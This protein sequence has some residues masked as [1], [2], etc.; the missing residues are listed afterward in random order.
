MPSRRKFSAYHLTGF[1]KVCQC[2]ALQF[3]GTYSC[4]VLHRTIAAILWWHSLYHVYIFKNE[5]Y[6]DWRL[7]AIISQSVGWS[8]REFDVLSSIPGPSQ[9]HDSHVRSRFKLISLNINIHWTRHRYWILIIFPKIMRGSVRLGFK[10]PYPHPQ[11]I[12][13]KT[14]ICLSLYALLSDATY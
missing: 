11:D 14:Y 10:H 2:D 13:Q 5:I 9:T 12:C 1:I 8:P 4:H 7:T 3:C 6:F